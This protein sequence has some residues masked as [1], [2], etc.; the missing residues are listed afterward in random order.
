MKKY[1]Y[2]TIAL[3]SFSYS[4]SQKAYNRVNP[5][6][7]YIDLDTKTAKI[8]YDSY[9]VSGNIEQIQVDYRNN[10]LLV[11]GGDIHLV[12]EQYYSDTDKYQEF[13][14]F[15]GEYKDVLKFI[16]KLKAP[17]KLELIASAEAKSNQYGNRYFTDGPFSFFSE[18]GY[19]QYLNDVKLEQLIQKSGFEGVYKVKINSSSGISLLQV[20]EYGELIISTKGITL[21]TELPGIIEVRGTWSARSTRGFDDNLDDFEEELNGGRLTVAGNLSSGFGDIFSISMT[22]RAGGITT[23]AGRTSITTTFQI[24]EKKL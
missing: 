1:I 9:I 8:Q 23:A 20:E 13:W 7:F 19:S 12:L 4:I 16:K 22:Q 24:I 3:L 17:K 10:Y 21:L 15:R 18:T 14:L 11:N 5:E 2:L 6:E